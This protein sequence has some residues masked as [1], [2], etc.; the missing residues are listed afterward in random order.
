MKS[1]NN[2]FPVSGLRFLFLVACRA[3]TGPQAAANFVPS[4]PLGAEPAA[5][6][7]RPGAAWLDD[8]HERLHRRWAEG[9]LE[10]ARL[11]LPPQNKLNDPALEA[12]LHFGVG[13]DGS[14]RGVEVTRPSGNADFDAAAR[15]V[16]GDA[17]PL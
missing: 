13:P 11:Y 17:A 14:V 2:R 4:P 15:Q 7:G 10:Q 1:K 5:A 9:F 16:V 6:E 12:T 3:A 8:L